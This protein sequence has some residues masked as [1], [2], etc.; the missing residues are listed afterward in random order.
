MAISS[1]G[2]TCLQLHAAHIGRSMI[3]NE[4]ACRLRA[5]LGRLLASVVRS[6]F[7]TEAPVRA[8]SCRPS[9][10][11]RLDPQHPARPASPLSTTPTHTRLAPP[12]RPPTLSLQVPTSYTHNWLSPPWQTSAECSTF[13]G[14]ISAPPLEKGGD[15][16]REDQHA[17][18]PCSECHWLMQVC[19]S[20]AQM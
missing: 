11:H 13:K 5:S 4:C 19:G 10:P 20:L 8:H 9:L 6:P 14:I 16:V 1:L 15:Q 2:V 12:D 17:L 18:A 3:P 7:P